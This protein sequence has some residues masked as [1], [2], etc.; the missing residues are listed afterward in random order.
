MNHSYMKWRYWPKNIHSSYIIE[1][2]IGETFGTFRKLLE[3]IILRENG[4]LV[5][6]V[7]QDTF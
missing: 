1:R 5:G 7:T 4:Y 2:L 3:T 6:C